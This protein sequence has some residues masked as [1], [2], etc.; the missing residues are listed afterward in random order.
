MS[1]K[2]F[3][4]LDKLQ[5][6]DKDEY[7]GVCSLNEMLKYTSCHGNYK[8]SNEPRRES[9]RHEVSE[10]Q[11]LH[12]SRLMKI[13]V[14]E[15]EDKVDFERDFARAS[16]KALIKSTPGDSLTNNSKLNNMQGE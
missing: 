11:N 16:Q 12:E 4:V 5:P 8:K 13:I 9:T 2:N 10:D 3:K 6:Q 1:L 7:F 15:S 14:E